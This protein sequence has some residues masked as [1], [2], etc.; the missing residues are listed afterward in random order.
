MNGAYAPMLPLF[1]YPLVE[2]SA[3]KLG[4][5]RMLWKDVADEFAGGQGLYAEAGPVHF[6]GQWAVKSDEEGSSGQHRTGEN[7]N[8]FA[9]DQVRKWL[10]AGTTDTDYLQGS[11]RADAVIATEG[12]GRELGSDVTSCFARYGA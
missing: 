4:V 3:A 2:P 12:L 11:V 8:I 1:G 5:V 9:V 6:A 7:M 10:L